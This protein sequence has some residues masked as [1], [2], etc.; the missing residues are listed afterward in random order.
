MQI[1]VTSLCGILTCVSTG[2]G[3]GSSGN[4]SSLLFSD[5][6]LAASLPPFPDVTKLAATSASLAEQ[7]LFLASIGLV[8]SMTKVTKDSYLTSCH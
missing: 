6:K 1:Q 2:A 3:W 5:S 8:L 4:D 7:L